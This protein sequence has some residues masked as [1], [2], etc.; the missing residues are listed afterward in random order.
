M[1]S[2]YARSI[3]GAT[4][5]RGS[6]T[7]ASKKRLRTSAPSRFSR[8]AWR[9]A[10][11]TGVFQVRSGIAF[12]AAG[13]AFQIDVSGQWHLR[14]MDL[15]DAQTRRLIGHRHIDQL[16]ETPRPQQGWIG[17]SRLVAPMTTTP[18][19]SSSPSVSAIMVFTTRSVMAGSPRPPRCGASDSI[20]SRGITAGAT[21]RARR[22]SRE[23]CRSESPYPISTAGQR[24]WWR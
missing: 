19:S 13:Q 12:R 16:V 2:R 5:G 23:T 22:N 6:F 17:Q 24:I 18:C 14:G 3:S 4:D 15:E 21:C 7:D 20:S 9:L 10:R 11:R 1:S 8:G